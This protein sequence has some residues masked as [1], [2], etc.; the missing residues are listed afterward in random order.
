MFLATYQYF[1]QNRNILIYTHYK[2]PYLIKREI[3]RINQLSFPDRVI[4][5]TVLPLTIPTTKLALI[6]QITKYAYNIV[7]YDL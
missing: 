1:V 6:N 2:A 7:L 4:G 3:S 5:S